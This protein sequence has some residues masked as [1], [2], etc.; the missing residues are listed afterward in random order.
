MGD[1][2]IPGSCRFRGQAN[3][4]NGGDRQIPG[5]LAPRPPTLA[6]LARGR[7]RLAATCVGT[8]KFRPLP[9]TQRLPSSA[10]LAWASLAWGKSRGQANSGDR[11]IPGGPN[12]AAASASRHGLGTAYPGATC[13]GTGKFR[14]V[15]T[16]R[17]LP[18]AGLAWASLVWG[19]SRGQANSG[20]RQIPGTG[21]SRVGINSGGQA[22]S[23]EGQISGSV[24]QRPPPLAGLAWCNLRGEETAWGQANSG[25]LH[26]ATT[27]AIWASQ[28]TDSPG[29][30]RRGDRQIPRVGTNSGGQANSGQGLENSAAA[31]ATGLA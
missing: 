27:S 21:K 1:R 7:P 9:A 11:Q 8:G 5:T 25:I 17:P 24:D 20:D 23:G 2:Q 3:S 14:A 28:G 13:V 15:A 29:C 19:K 4:G 12:S 22:N 30:N 6:G 31:S 18:L 10:G 26:S 16:Q